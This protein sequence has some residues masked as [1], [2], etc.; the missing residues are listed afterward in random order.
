MVCI[1]THRNIDSIQ[2][3]DVIVQQKRRRKK[4]NGESVMKWRRARARERGATQRQCERTSQKIESRKCK[5][6]TLQKQQRPK[7]EQQNNRRRARA[8]QHT[9]GMR[10]T[11]SKGVQERRPRAQQHRAREQRHQSKRKRS[12]NKPQKDRNR[13]QARGKKSNK[14]TATSAQQNKSAAKQELNSQQHR[15]S[16]ACVL[17]LNG[18]MLAK[19]PIALCPPRAL[20]VVPHVLRSLHQRATWPFYQRRALVASLW[21]S[22]RTH[23]TACTSDPLSVACMPRCVGICTFV[24]EKQVLL[25]WQSNAHSDDKSAAAHACISGEEEEGFFRGFVTRMQA[26]LLGRRRMRATRRLLRVRMRTRTFR[27]TRL[28]W[29]DGRMKPLLLEEQVGGGEVRVGCSVV[30]LRR[31]G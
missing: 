6:Q 26:R 5:E 11:E 31:K 17:Q 24:V 27:V 12:N 22:T 30:E 18:D 25:Y 28:R 16:P 13:E 15:S 10:A 3:N 29:C 8:K 1:Y 19:I 21:R 23:G 2:N 20:V 9:P 14:S 4:G 7:R